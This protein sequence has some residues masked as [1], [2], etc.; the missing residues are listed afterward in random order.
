MTSREFFQEIKYEWCK[1][2]E[3]DKPLLNDM[4]KFA[5]LYHKEQLELSSVGKSSKLLN[6]K[7]GDYVSY[8]GGS[9]SKYLI[10]GN[11]YRLT[12]DTDKTSRNRVSLVNEKGTRMVIRSRFFSI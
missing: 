6:T 10:K 2:D 11:K 12:C 1:S 5:K 4:L 3:Q 9:E 8:L 7:R